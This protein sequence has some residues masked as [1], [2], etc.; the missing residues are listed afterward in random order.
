[1]FRHQT[2]PAR[3]SEIQ[4]RRIAR[5]FADNKG[6]I[7]TAQAFFKREQCVLRLV[8]GN[9]DQAVTQPF[10]QAGA[11]RPTRQ[12]DRRLVLHPQPWALIRRII[13]SIARHRQCQRRAAAFVSRGKQF[14]VANVSAQAGPPARGAAFILPVPGRQTARKLVEGQCGWAQR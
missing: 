2:E 6:Q 12:A 4:R 1:M 11:I 5:H 7:A 8:S 14:G 13:G 10:R 3:R 9:M